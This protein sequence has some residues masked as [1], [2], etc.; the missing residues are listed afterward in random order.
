VI[1]DV[2]MPGQTGPEMVVGLLLRRP[3]LAVLFVTGFAG[4]ACEAE[5]GG[6]VVLRKPFTIAGLEAAIHDAVAAPGAIESH[7]AAE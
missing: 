5:F 1:S 2:L 3:D 6:H 7:I 4:E